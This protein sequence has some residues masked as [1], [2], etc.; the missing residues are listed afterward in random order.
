M[1]HRKAPSAD[2][3]WRVLLAVNGGLMRGMSQ[4]QRMVDVGAVFVSD[5]TTQPQYRLWAINDSYPAM[6]REMY[7]GGAAIEVEVYSVSPEALVQLFFDEPPELTLGH[8]TLSDDTTVVCVL[9]ESSVTVGQV[10]ITELG[11]WRE[12]RRL[13]GRLP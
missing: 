3:Q 5:E 4:H 8:V 2:D 9:G 6:V 12:Y 11:G 10:E 13:E 7:G 1:T